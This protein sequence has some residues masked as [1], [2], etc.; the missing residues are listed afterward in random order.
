MFSF[1]TFTLGF[2]PP[3]KMLCTASGGA[4]QLAAAAEDHDHSFARANV[5][6]AILVVILFLTLLFEVGFHAK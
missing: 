5:T 3:A 1:L 6:I 4:C 2:A